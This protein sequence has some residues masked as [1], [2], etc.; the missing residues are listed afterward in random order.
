MDEKGDEVPTT[1]LPIELSLLKKSMGDG[2]G[3]E[4]V[5]DFNWLF[6]QLKTL[7]VHPKQIQR[8]LDQLDIRLVITAHP[9]E[10][11]RHTIRRKQRRIDIILLKLDQLQGG[12]SRLDWL[13]SWEARSEMDKLTEEIRFWW[14]T[15]ELHQFKP[16]VLDE[17]DYALHYFDEVLF[18]AIPQLAKRL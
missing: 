17:V 5:G 10:I 15:D 2:E 4:Q 3:M 9:T 14:R 16:T 18:D 1:P 13:N 12:V 8:L 7:N 6:G 11:V